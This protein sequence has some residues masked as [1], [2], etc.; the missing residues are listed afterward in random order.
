M[1]RQAK[2]KR[3]KSFFTVLII[4]AICAVAI[5]LLWPSESPEGEPE[6]SEEKG[7]EKEEAKPAPRKRD[8]FFDSIDKASH[9]E[10]G[11]YDKALDRAR[12]AGQ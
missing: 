2:G 12:N 5:Y 6:V 10:G 9:P 11:V 7:K 8:G 3:M 4:L 1:R